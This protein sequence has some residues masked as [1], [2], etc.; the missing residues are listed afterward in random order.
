MPEL[1]PVPSTRTGTVNAP[2]KTHE[3]GETLHLP[4]SPEGKFRQEI[5][6]AAQLRKE[7]T[8]QRFIPGGIPSQVPT[9]QRNLSSNSLPM[10]LLQ[11][12]SAQS[13]HD[14]SD[15]NVHRNSE[16][17]AQVGALA[18]AQGNDIHL[19]AGQEQHLA[20]EAAHVVQQREGRVQPNTQVA[21]LAVNDNPQLEKEADSVAEQVMRT[22]VS[23][24][25]GAAA[26]NPPAVQRKVAASP[27]VAEAIQRKVS[28]DDEEEEEMETV[29]QGKFQQIGELGFPQTYSGPIQWTTRPQQ[30][31]MQRQVIQRIGD[32]FVLEFMGVVNS[33]GGPAYNEVPRAYYSSYPGAKTLN[34]E[35]VMDGSKPM[36]LVAGTSVE[37]GQLDGK[38]WRRVHIKP[39]GR[40]NFEIVWVLDD[41][42]DNPAAPVKAKAVTPVADPE[43]AKATTTTVAPKPTNK[44]LTKVVEIDLDTNGSYGSKELHVTMTAVGND[45]QLIFKHIAGT[46]T[47][48]VTVTPDNIALQ[49]AVFIGTTT[50]DGIHPIMLVTEGPLLEKQNEVGRFS[51]LIGPTNAPGAFK[52]KGLKKDA[53]MDLTGAQDIDLGVPAT[54]AP[55]TAAKIIEP[56]GGIAEQGGAFKFNYKVGAALDL[57]ASV[58]MIKNPNQEKSALCSFEGTQDSLGKTIQTFPSSKLVLPLPVKFE[59]L[60]I[61]QSGSTSN[62]VLYKFLPDTTG[63]GFMITY[64]LNP[65]GNNPFESKNALHRMNLYPISTATGKPGEIMPSANAS[66]KMIDGAWQYGSE[67]RSIES[68]RIESAKDA[69]SKLQSMK[70][71]A[72]EI[73]ALNNEMSMVVMMAVKAKVA[74]AAIFGQWMELAVGVEMHSP[75]AAKGDDTA[76]SWLK[77]KSTAFVAAL[78]AEIGSDGTTVSVNASGMGPAGGTVTTTTGNKFTG[79][80]TVDSKTIVGTMPTTSTQTVKQPFEQVKAYIAAAD[81]PSAI[82]SLR[83][84]YYMWV[85]DQLLNNKNADEATKKQLM[86]YGGQM[87]YKREL[88]NRLASDKKPMQRLKA[89]YYPDL[90]NVTDENDKAK[91]AGS[92]TQGIP[93]DIFYQDTGTDWEICNFST[94]TQPGKLNS[95]KLAFP[96]QADQK[97]PSTK[98]FD[99]LNADKGLGKG[100]IHYQIR[101]GEGGIVRIDHPWTLGEVLLTTAAV[102]GLIALALTGVGLLAEGAAATSIAGAAT[103]MGNIAAVAAASGAAVSI[104]QDKQK[105]VAITPERWA[106]LSIAVATAVLPAIRGLRGIGSL[107]KYKDMFVLMD[108][109]NNT[110]LLTKLDAAAN[111]TAIIVTTAKGVEELSQLSEALEKGRIDESTFYWAVLKNV[112]MGVINVILLHGTMKAMG[113]RA[114][115]GTTVE[116]I[117]S[118]GLKKGFIFEK[119]SLYNKETVTKG[120]DI[121]LDSASVYRN[122]VVEALASEKDFKKA[123]DVV[124]YLGAK[125]R[126]SINDALIIDG[127]VKRAID[128]MIEGKFFGKTLTIPQGFVGSPSEKLGTQERNFEEFSN[129][130]VDG[131]HKVP[132]L[133]NAEIRLQGSATMGIAVPKEA[134]TPWDYDVAIMMEPAAFRQKMVALFHGKA[135][136]KAENAAKIDLAAMSDDAIIALA[137]KMHADKLAKTGLY[138]SKAHDFA[139][140][141]VNGRMVV[142]DKLTKNLDVLRKTV[143]KEYGIP[144]MD[145]GIVAKQGVFDS[146]PFILLKSTPKAVPVPPAPTTPPKTD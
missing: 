21:G 73:H 109:V 88:K 85:E 20:H 15:V 90:G 14:L 7:A 44:I 18:F 49:D 64:E 113:G 67:L 112:G 127:K 9:I 108:K 98:M 103:V 8:L 42:I 142:D 116:N 50:T 31:V 84:A 117:V 53:N 55:A 125:G 16:K 17:P 23:D 136:L 131:V 126:G 132:G 71:P 46:K 29:V 39:P 11:G 74:S 104:Y 75:A 41:Y 66:F 97:V 59:E 91:L 40:E 144:D 129:A 51:I 32:P 28:A 58:F 13:G 22:P 26:E 1:T 43:K 139:N 48:S 124:A 133:E 72:D 78:Q 69:F 134:G 87:T 96:K 115:A 145:F 57:G 54:F 114:L 122:M 118:D 130:M 61:E 70:L 3:G 38:H 143:L 33:N 140:N 6:A 141:V 100:Y 25:G 62:S 2:A 35:K 30:A 123:I 37:C 121:L 34:G 135:N 77:E 106:E 65:G 110:Q 146:T 80:S 52:I 92:A 107:T 60:K 47:A 111:A 86:Q 4:L 128:V 95:F 56:I 79:A 19:G 5:G 137:Q 27:S 138:N 94:L 102:I 68:F 10:D 45:I 101:E 93:L 12:I 36:A 99:G 89:I 82:A 24:L 105:G 83:G 76:K 63:A 120:I 119:S 81:Y